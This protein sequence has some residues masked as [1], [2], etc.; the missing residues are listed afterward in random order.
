M[1][2]EVTLHVFL[3]KRDRDYEPI[4]IGVPVPAGFDT[5]DDQRE[6]LAQHACQLVNQRVNEAHGNEGLE[7]ISKEALKYRLFKI[8]GQQ[9][10]W[11][12]FLSAKSQRAAVEDP[13]GPHG[14][15]SG[16]AGRA[17]ASAQNIINAILATGGGGGGAILNAKTILFSIGAWMTGRY[18]QSYSGS[19]VHNEYV[20][21]SVPG[22][23]SSAA[24]AA[25]PQPA[26]D[27]SSAVL[28]AILDSIHDQAVARA[29]VSHMEEGT[30]EDLKTRCNSETYAM[31]MRAA[32]RLAPELP[33]KTMVAQVAHAVRQERREI[34]TAKERQRQLEI[35]QT[36]QRRLEHGDSQPLPSQT[37]V[38]EEDDSN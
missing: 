30:L 23:Q 1:S 12:A 6:T 13:D 25:Q 29:V 17:S 20:P 19:T 36:L 26:E 27:D 14:P 37:A 35:L 33:L 34:Q 32:E 3:Y 16:R 4:T 11:A 10:H 22:T 38:E 2:E 28:L 8:P 31:A 21:E 24:G 18:A 7:E 5:T 9:G 15:G